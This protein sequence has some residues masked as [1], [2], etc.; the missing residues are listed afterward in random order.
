[1]IYYPVREFLLRRTVMD[2]K[3]KEEKTNKEIEKRFLR[4]KVWYVE[5]DKNAKNNDS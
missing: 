1:M 3:R 5:R 4:L 2:R